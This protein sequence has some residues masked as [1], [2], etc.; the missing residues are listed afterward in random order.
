MKVL[1]AAVLILLW[2][3][4]F[5]LPPPSL[6]PLPPL[7]RLPLSALTGACKNTLRR[8]V[9]QGGD[10]KTSLCRCL[11]ALGITW[12]IALNNSSGAWSKLT[13]KNRVVVHCRGDNSKMRLLHAPFFF[14]FFF[15]CMQFYF[16]GNTQAIWKRSPAYISGAT[17]HRPPE[18]P[19]TVCRYPVSLFWARL[20]F[21]SRLACLPKKHADKKLKKR[22]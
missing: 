10:G 22:L 3:S 7:D 1:V 12:P 8:L 11:G 4:L 2:R 19:Q 20:H 5:L 18:A 17:M 9:S 15:L 21:V 16:Y 6:P 14:S 13:G